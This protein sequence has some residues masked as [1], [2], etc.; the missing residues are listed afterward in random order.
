MRVLVVSQYYWPETFI[1]TAEIARLRQEGIEVTVLTGKPNYP[2]GNVFPGYRAWGIQHE[3]HE[4]TEIVRLPIFP[5]GQNSAIRL[6]LNYLSFVLSAAFFGPFVLR[7]RSFETVFV[8]ALSPILQAL[9]AIPIARCK[10]ARLVLW[11][12]D[13]WPESLSA[14]GFVKNLHVLAA[15]RQVVRFIYRRSDRILVQ[16]RAFRAPVAALTDDPGKIHYVPNPV[17]DLRPPQT[18]SPEIRALADQIGTGFSIVFAGNLGRAQALDTVMDAAGRLS[19]LPQVKLFLI[20]SGSMEPWLHD[21][22]SRRGLSNVALP[23]RFPSDAMPVLL[24][25]ASALLVSLRAEEIFAHTVP[26]KLQTYFAIGR[27]VI[28]MLD[29]EG[30]AI[31]TEAGAGLTCPP[32]DAEA[33]AL[34]I[35]TMYETS[36]QDRQAMGAAARTYFEAE[37]APDKITAALKRHLIAARD[38]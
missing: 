11:V 38:D 15:V 34:A 23:G 27:P 32:G 8:Y 25:K 28:A 16:S 14:T 20:G 5:R 6:M 13:L 18:P 2:S 22:V 9:P 7:G 21:E 4:G 33:L 17:P 24:P 29:G 30:A 10:R 19:D 1:I 37:F 26:S 35:R 3:K 12:Q 36:Q 31:L